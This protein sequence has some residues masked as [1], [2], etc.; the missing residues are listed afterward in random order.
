[1]GP[2]SRFP[3]KA[4]VGRALHVETT[5]SMV[6]ERSL[7]FMLSVASIAI[8]VAYS[9]FL[10]K[11]VGD[12]SVA[13][14]ILLLLLMTLGGFVLVLSRRRA[15]L[16]E[17]GMAVPNL[18]LFEC[19]GASVILPFDRTTPVGLVAGPGG[20]TGWVLAA[21]DGRRVTIWEGSFPDP[22]AA[23]RLLISVFRDKLPGVRCG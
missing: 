2:S 12:V 5:R 3:H 4:D 6:A 7:G 15:T 23:H 19:F 22:E 20:D 14:I 9:G 11:S 16:Y 1:M 10:V 18:R 13:A 21:N 17:G 8:L